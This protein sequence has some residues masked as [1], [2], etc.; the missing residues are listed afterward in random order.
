MYVV[1]PLIDDDEL[2]VFG[3]SKAAKE[4]AE[5]EAF[6]TTGADKCEVHQ[7]ED[8][9]DPKQAVA[10]VKAGKSK[11]LVTI[12]RRLRASEI[13]VLERRDAEAFLREL[14]L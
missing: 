12:H 14:G 6:A 8:D 13:E 10:A 2:K 9:L 7:V 5:T 1:K 11:L 3:T 4:Y